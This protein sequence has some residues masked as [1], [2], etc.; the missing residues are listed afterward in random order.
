MSYLF[1]YVSKIILHFQTQWQ[2]LKFFP[3]KVVVASHDIPPYMVYI[4][5]VLAIFLLFPFNANYLSGYIYIY[6]VH[7]SLGTNSKCVQHIYHYPWDYD[8]TVSR[9][10][11]LI[12]LFIIIS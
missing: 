11:F 9:F 10:V 4:R 2:S 12:R 7:P 1:I 5:H 8:R 3:G 6:Q